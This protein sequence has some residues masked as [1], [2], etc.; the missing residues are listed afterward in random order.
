MAGVRPFSL[1]RIH[2][3]PLMLSL[4]LYLA[5]EAVKR[6][7]YNLAVDMWATGAVVFELLHGDHPFW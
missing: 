1:A 2:D 7:P 4:Q 6:M 3:G 5:P